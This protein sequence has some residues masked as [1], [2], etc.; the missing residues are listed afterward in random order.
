MPLTSFYLYQYL[1]TTVIEIFIQWIKQLKKEKAI[2]RQHII[3]SS[4]F[5]LTALSL[6]LYIFGHRE[7]KL[8]WFMLFFRHSLLA[9]HLVSEI[10]ENLGVQLCISDILQHSTLH[11]LASFIEKPTET[12][13][14]ITLD[15]PAVVERYSQSKAPWVP[16]LW[17][18]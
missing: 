13:S 17:S 18:Y 10:N 3:A 5:R 14:D 12:T 2:T 16:F 1:M 7:R 15:L 4:I 6:L 11:S 8:N 9:T